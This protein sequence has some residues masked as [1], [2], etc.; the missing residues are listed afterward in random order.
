MRLVEEKINGFTLLSIEEERIDAH[1]SEELKLTILHLIEDGEINIIV[2]LKNVRFID[3]SGLGALLSGHKNAS[4]KSGKIILITI[5]PQV[6]SMFEL[7]RLDRVF[8]IYAN[9]DEAINC[10]LERL[11]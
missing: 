5:Q 10:Q 9:L 2:Q 1:N 3:G 7:T 6:F 11:I 4:S 8:E